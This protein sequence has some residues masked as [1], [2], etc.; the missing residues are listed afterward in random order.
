[1]SKS[2]SMGQKQLGTAKLVGGLG[3]V[4]SGEK[5]AIT[6]LGFIWATRCNQAA[7]AQLSPRYRC[8]RRQIRREDNWHSFAVDARSSC[9]LLCTTAGLN[10]A[11]SDL[12][13]WWHHSTASNDS[14][15]G[16]KIKFS[17]LYS[18]T[19]KRWVCKSRPQQCMC[20][21]T[22]SLPLLLKGDLS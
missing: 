9:C 21:L 11:L 7:K 1:M 16:L 5:K 15:C 13:F 3:G 12:A 14:S 20:E 6:G 18:Y 4:G 19:S 17:K 8:H 2:S 10:F 22:R